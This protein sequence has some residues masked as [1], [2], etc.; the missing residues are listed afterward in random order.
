MPMPMPIPMP[1]SMPRCRCRDF[2]MAQSTDNYP[3]FEV[4]DVKREAV[5]LVPTKSDHYGYTRFL[6]NNAV[7]ENPYKFTYQYLKRFSIDLLLNFTMAMT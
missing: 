3:N 1:M 7:C 2:Q 6:Y 5:V 4:N